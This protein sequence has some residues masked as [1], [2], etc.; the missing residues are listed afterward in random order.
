MAKFIF[1]MVMDQQKSEE[2]ILDI[3]SLITHQ[4]RFLNK[5]F[6]LLNVTIPAILV[7]RI[8][9]ELAHTQNIIILILF[10]QYNGLEPGYL[11]RRLRN[12]KMRSFNENGALSCIFA[13]FSNTEVNWRIALYRLKKR[14][15]KRQWPINFEIL[16][17]ICTHANVMAEHTSWDG[18]KTV[19]ITC[20][21]TPGSCSLTA[22][23]LT[24]SG[25]ARLSDRKM[26]ILFSC[27]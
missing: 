1:C 22:Y 7:V 5:T 13:C 19:I 15:Y 23:K 24:P 16:Q 8:H 11:G 4:S 14:G 2:S 3:F 9:F 10:C 6:K 21:F 26:H 12:I 18:E 25:K 20:S 27:T 17:D